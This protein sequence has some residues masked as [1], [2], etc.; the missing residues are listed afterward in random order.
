MSMFKFNLI[1]INVK[2]GQFLLISC[3]QKKIQSIIKNDAIVVFIFMMY[4]SY[5]FIF[6]TFE[7]MFTFSYYNL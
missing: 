6:Y 5:K 3:Y 1:Y 7:S 4:I 2:E